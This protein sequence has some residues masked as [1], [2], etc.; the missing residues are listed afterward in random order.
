MEKHLIAQRVRNRVLEYLE[1]V[2]TA[3]VDVPNLKTSDIVNLWE[4]SV[5]DMPDPVFEMPP[6]S[7]DEAEALSVFAEAWERFCIE[8]PAWPV[9]YAS[10]F[11]HPAWPP[12]REAAVSAWKTLNR[13]GPLPED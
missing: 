11:A 9:T 8:T 5:D 7:R 2:A 13:R 6:Y 4:D 3:E 12:F 10:L 1:L